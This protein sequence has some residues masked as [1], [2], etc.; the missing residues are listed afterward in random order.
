MVDALRP[1]SLPKNSLRAGSKS[2][3][4]VPRRYSTGSTSV[5][6]GERRAQGGRMA[7]VKR[8]PSRRSWTRGA[9]ILRAPAAVVTVRLLRHSVADHQ[10]VPSFITMVG[11]LGNVL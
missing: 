8:R 7:L 9:W 2:L 10:R 5:T 1:A 3:V 6:L 4:E 11:V